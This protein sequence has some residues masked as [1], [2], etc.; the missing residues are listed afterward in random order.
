MWR[1]CC[2]LC[3]TDGL[4]GKRASSLCLGGLSFLSKLGSTS[5][6]FFSAISVSWNISKSCFNV[7]FCWCYFFGISSPIVSKSVSSCVLIFFLNESFWIH[8]WS[9]FIGGNFN[10]PRYVISSVAPWT[11]F[12][13]CTLSII[14]SIVSLIFSFCYPF[15]LNTLWI[16]C[17]GIERQ[18]NHQRGS[19]CMDWPDSQWPVTNRLKKVTQSAIGH[20][21]TT[22]DL[23]NNCGLIS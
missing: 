7:K 16:Y 14:T 2:F 20:M 12:L 6:I 8:V 17:W 15:S 9:L 10:I 23:H 22:F 13:T 1:V 11:F 18:Y 19:L 21:I 5:K 4:C 3:M